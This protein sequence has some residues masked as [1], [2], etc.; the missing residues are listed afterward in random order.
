M[1]TRT[2]RIVVAVVA[3]V[4]LFGTWIFPVLWTAITSLKTAADIFSY[5]P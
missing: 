3:G 4:V 5:P 2:T 1:I